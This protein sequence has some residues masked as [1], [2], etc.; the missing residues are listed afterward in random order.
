MPTTLSPR[1]AR[2]RRPAAP[3]L[4]GAAAAAL[5]GAAY[6]AAVRALLRR[7]VTA[8]MAGDPEPLL[9]MYAPGAVLH[10]PGEHTWGPVY[11]GREA[12]GGFL[13]RFLDAGL[14]GELTDIYVA[15]PPWAT[16][17]AVRFDDHAH[18][19]ATGERIYENRA[20]IVLQTRLGRV[21]REEVFEDTQ[22]VAAFDARVAVAA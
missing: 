5:T 12:I 10:F 8:L 18:D 3:F 6:P 15:G 17:I 22:K 21:V 11:D 13:R 16:R 14:R 2:R 7:N 4:A 19:A 20:V 1:R 9:R